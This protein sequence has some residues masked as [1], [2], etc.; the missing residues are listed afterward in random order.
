[1]S[2][3][4][5]VSGN[6]DDLSPFIFYL[7]LSLCLSLPLSSFLCGHSAAQ[8]EFKLFS[9]FSSPFALAMLQ[10]QMVENEEQENAAKST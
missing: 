4:T 5:Y 7:Y 8:F 9:S 10:N 3:L 2:V 1:M 6:V